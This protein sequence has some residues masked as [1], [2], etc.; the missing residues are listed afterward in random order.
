ME[1]L[2]L[3]FSSLDVSFELS[4]LT[5]F[6]C[7]SGAFRFEDSDA[8]LSVK[9]SQRVSDNLSFRWSLDCAVGVGVEYFS[10]SR[11]KIFLFCQSGDR[12][13]GPL[14]SFLVKTESSDG[15]LKRDFEGAVDGGRVGT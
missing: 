1:M 7:D 9:S 2:I 10:T 8:L 12:K 3:L 15:V 6:R 5:R 11:W 14:R 13:R 4:C